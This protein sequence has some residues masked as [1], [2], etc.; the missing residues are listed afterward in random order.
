MNDKEKVTASTLFT[1]ENTNKVLTVT[2][3]ATVQPVALMRLGV[4]V[5]KPARKKG[6]LAA[7]IDAS[8]HL[9]KLE[10]ARAEGYDDVLITGERLDME[11]D[12][13]VW[14][15]IVHSF[16]K[17]GLHSN[18]ITIPYLTF[19]KLCGFSAKRL[20]KKL[21]ADIKNS[22]AKIRNKGIT[23]SKK[24]SV[25]S[26]YITGLL[27]TGQLDVDKNIVILEADSSI[28]E[29]YQIDYKILL[30]LNVIKELQQKE[31]AQAIYTF[32][33]ALP[34]NP[35]PLSFSRIRDRLDLKS[36]KKEQNRTIKNAIAHLQ[37]I[38]YLSC[39]IVKREGDKENYVI[40]HSRN[41]KLKMPID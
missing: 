20:G 29:L 13:K 32:I 3:N 31:T 21:K 36:A 6:M 9:S 27:K 17:Y 15:G 22:L 37:K 23:F 11:I 39:S 5:P 30:Q 28:W 40:I 41:P 25:G 18:T 12:F 1:N 2:N 35:A 26:A 7:P 38:G 19:A 4:F 16:S 34:Q 33:E 8:N 10:F 24:D 14:I